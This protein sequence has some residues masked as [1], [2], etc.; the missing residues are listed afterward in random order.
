MP[1]CSS[2]NSCF[3]THQSCAEALLQLLLGGHGGVHTC[4]LSRG[5]GGSQTP[6][7]IILGDCG[8]SS[9]VPHDY[10]FRESK[11]DNKS[12]KKKSSCKNVSYLK[13]CGTR[14]LPVS[15]SKPL[16]WCIS[17]PFS[18]L[19]DGLQ[20]AEGWNP[21]QPVKERQIPGHYETLERGKEISSHWQTQ[22]DSRGSREEEELRAG[23]FNQEHKLSLL[24]GKLRAVRCAQVTWGPPSPAATM[25]TKGAGHGE[26]GDPESSR[27][28]CPA[29]RQR[30]MLHVWQQR[31][32]WVLVPPS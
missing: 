22:S 30:Q 1:H 24:W 4:R 23:A 18:S 3:Q 6:G 17:R 16:C 31:A 8:T 13:L 25:S 12:L 15:A 11:Q 7:V 19:A 26:G 32:H 2:L 28:A 9:C 29:Q 21:P 10:E 27:P 14:G 20:Q 5:P